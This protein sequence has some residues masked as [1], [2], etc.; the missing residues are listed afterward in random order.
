[1][2]TP[3]C[4]QPVGRPTGAL[5]NEDGQAAAR[6]FTCLGERHVPATREHHRDGRPAGDRLGDV[7]QQLGL[8]TPFGAVRENEV[9]VMRLEWGAVPV[10]GVSRP[11]IGDLACGRDTDQERHGVAAL[12]A[13]RCP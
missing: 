5:E 8:A 9:A 11:R 12:G 7:E 13:S 10:G 4:C 1:M 3:K 2:R 6:R